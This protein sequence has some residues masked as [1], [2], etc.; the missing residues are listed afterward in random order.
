MVSLETDLPLVSYPIARAGVTAEV[1][2]TRSGQP[3]FGIELE[4]GALPAG[5][6]VSESTTTTTSSF[7]FFSKREDP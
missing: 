4:V 2:E 6:S 5:A 1:G 7:T 3:V